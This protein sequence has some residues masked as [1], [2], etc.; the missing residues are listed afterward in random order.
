MYA[1][2]KPVKCAI[3]YAYRENKRVTRGKGFLDDGDGWYS[4]SR[5]VN[6]TC[7]MLFFAYIASTS[8]QYIVKKG[9]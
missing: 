5:Q 9:Y 1:S 6:K 2:K 7:E 4:N 3:S 8:L